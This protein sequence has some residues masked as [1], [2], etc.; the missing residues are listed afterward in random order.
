VSLRLHTTNVAPEGFRR[1]LLSRP[2]DLDYG[3]RRPAWARRSAGTLPELGQAAGRGVSYTI[4]ALGSHD[5]EMVAGRPGRHALP[6][7]AEI[8]KGLTV[9]DPPAT[10]PLGPCT[11]LIGYHSSW[12]LWE[13]QAAEAA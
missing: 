2:D 5:G 3:Q 8:G 1:G 10:A 6:G 7:G 11:T 13:C 4:D 9:P 12:D